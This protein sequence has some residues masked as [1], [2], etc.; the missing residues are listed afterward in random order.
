MYDGY[1]QSI[2]DL[3]IRER[4]KILALG[5]EVSRRESVL[6][7]LQQKLT[8]VRFGLILVVCR[9]YSLHV[10]HN[11]FIFVVRCSSIFITCVPILCVNYQVE[12]DHAAWMNKHK[13]ASDAEL[14]HHTEMMVR[15]L[16]CMYFALQ[17]RALLCLF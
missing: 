17:R 6:T 4:N 13:S 16:F 2:L 3:Q 9:L 5:K 14:R 11:V 8:E 1:P 15:L 12:S 10:L 7:A